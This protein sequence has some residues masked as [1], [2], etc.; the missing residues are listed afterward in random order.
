MR[1]QAVRNIFSENV[2]LLQPFVLITSTYLLPDISVLL[3][4]TILICIY[5]CDLFCWS[6]IELFL[7]QFLNLFSSVGQRYGNTLT[8]LV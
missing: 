8:Y 2:F 5:S 3:F 4:N 1:R 6:N 7:F